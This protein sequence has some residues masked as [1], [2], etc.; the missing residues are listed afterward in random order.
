MGKYVLLSELGTSIL[1]Q[2][3][4]GINIRTVSDGT[5]KSELWQGNSFQN[6]L[7]LNGV[8]CMSLIYESALYNECKW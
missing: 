7:R 2:Q 6:D 5:Y 8:H 1:K 3:Q 4:K